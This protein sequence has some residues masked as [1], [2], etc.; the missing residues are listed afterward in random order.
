MGNAITFGD[1]S[2]GYQKLEGDLRLS[3][4]ISQEINLLLR[5]TQNLRNSQFISYCGSING[6]GSDTIRV[7]KA[8]LDGYD[9]FE[10][11][12][13]ESDAVKKELKTVLNA[14]VDKDMSKDELKETDEKPIKMFTKYLQEKLF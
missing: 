13:N 9:L 7:R 4:M 11:P 8:G 5:D 6:M 10:T 3:A 2:A 12:A 14:M 1:N